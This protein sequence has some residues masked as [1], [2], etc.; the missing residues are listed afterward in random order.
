MFFLWS[1]GPRSPVSTDRTLF[2]YAMRCLDTLPSLSIQKHSVVK[3]IT[4]L[5]IRQKST[6]RSAWVKSWGES[7]KILST[8]ICII[9]FTRIFLVLFPKALTST[10]LCT[11]S[12]RLTRPSEIK[13]SCISSVRRLIWLPVSITAGICWL[14]IHKEPVDNSLTFPWLHKA[15]VR[16]RY[17]LVYKVHLCTGTEALYRP[18]GP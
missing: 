18:Y 5:F 9:A 10:A 16:F 17:R 14:P 11:P 12:S 15:V 8:R 1:V 7:R 6:P 3:S 4:T 2:A 13:F